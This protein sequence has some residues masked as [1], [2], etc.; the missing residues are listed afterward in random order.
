[1]PPPTITTGIFLVELGRGIWFPRSKCPIFCDGPRISPSKSLALPRDAQD[2]KLAAAT[3]AL[4]MRNW[5]RFIENQAKGERVKAK[6]LRDEGRM[7]SS[8]G[9][10]QSPCRL[11]SRFRGNDARGRASTWKLAYS[12]HPVILTSA[13]V[14][15][16]AGP[17]AFR[18]DP[19][20]LPSRR[21]L[22]PLGFVVVHERL[23]VEAVHFSFNRLHILWKLKQ[24][25]RSVGA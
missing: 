18:L 10:T 9:L 11:D 8:Y 16:L 25:R 5:R 6:R 1:M 2:P 14:I 17:F 24:A 23:I 19:F 22:L 13:F 12:S 7:T 4:E 21:H 15:L 3:P 20:A